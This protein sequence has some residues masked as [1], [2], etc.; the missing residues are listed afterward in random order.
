MV[1]LVSLFPRHR[2]H[3]QILR[4]FNGLRILHRRLIP[5][6]TEG[7]CL[8]VEEA[9]QVNVSI[10]PTTIRSNPLMGHSAGQDLVI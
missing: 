3:R 4:L 2:E 7:M 9:C 10:L 5:S 1:L 8:I 6:A